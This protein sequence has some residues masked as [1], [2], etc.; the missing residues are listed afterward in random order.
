MNYSKQREEILDEL[1]STYSHPTAEEVYMAV[2]AKDNS[3]SRSTVYRNLNQLVDNNLVKRITTSVGID[4]YDYVRDIHNHVVCIK[5][6]KVF[7]FDYR[8]N[9]KRIRFEVN[10]QIGVEVFNTGITFEGICSECKN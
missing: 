10:N 1:K 5:C 2:K 6:G 8:F 3:V 4:R 9:Y 7:D